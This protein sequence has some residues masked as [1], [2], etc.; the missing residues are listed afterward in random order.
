MNAASSGLG[1]ARVTRAG[2]GVAP[3]RIFL[4]TQLQEGAHYS[5]R[6][7]PHFEKPWATYTVTRGS[8]FRRDAET[9]TRDACATSDTNHDG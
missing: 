7:L 3:W 5:R 4:E 2:D 8:S 1:S 9:S 6:R